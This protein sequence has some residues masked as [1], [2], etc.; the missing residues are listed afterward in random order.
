M[1]RKMIWAKNG[2]ISNAPFRA[3]TFSVHKNFVDT[4]DI[5]FL[6]YSRILR[7]STTRG[8]PPPLPSPYSPR[9]LSYPL[10]PSQLLPSSSPRLSPSCPHS[11]SPSPLALL[12]PLSP[13]AS[14]FQPPLPFS[15][16]S[17]TLFYV[18]LIKGS[19]HS[20]KTGCE[21]EL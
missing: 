15:L 4:F 14:L 8:Q 3:V 17:P 1:L 11:L 19:L 16:L 18:V 5:S 7:P 9:S 6:I 12:T 21:G 2:E 20:G 10:S 13:L